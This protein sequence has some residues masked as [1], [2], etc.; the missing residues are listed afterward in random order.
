[1]PSSVPSIRGPPFPSNRQA[2]VAASASYQLLQHN[3]GRTEYHHIHLA[4]GFR[5]RMC[6]SLGVINATQSLYRQTRCELINEPWSVAPSRPRGVKLARVRYHL[7]YPFHSLSLCRKKGGTL[8][9]NGPVRGTIRA[10]TT[11]PRGH[12]RDEG[13]NLGIERRCRPGAP[14][15]RRPRRGFKD[16]IYY[17]VKR[18]CL[19]HLHF[20]SHFLISWAASRGS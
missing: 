4:T 19:I 18:S 20:S 2:L 15:S 14:C 17:V 5:T 10:A 12:S 8:W 11:S 1:M 6:F 16:G 3:F 13:K 7:I 9:R